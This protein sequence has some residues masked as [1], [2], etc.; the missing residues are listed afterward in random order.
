VIEIGLLT[1]MLPRTC[2]LSSCLH[3]FC[4]AKPPYVASNSKG[5]IAFHIPWILA[6]DKGIMLGYDHMNEYDTVPG[7]REFLSTIPV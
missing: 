6:G 3:T 7:K 1:V 4:P 5:L 2:I